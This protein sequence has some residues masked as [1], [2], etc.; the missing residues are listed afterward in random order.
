MGRDIARETFFG[1]RVVHHLSDD[2]VD[3]LMAAPRAIAEHTGGRAFFAEDGDSL[4]KIYAE[5]DALERV[6]VGHVE[7]TS[8][9]ELYPWPL[10]AGLGLLM[11]AAF[12]DE[13]VFRRAP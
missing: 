10:L 8:Y 13:T 5:I 9:R 2:D 1:P 6:D 11:L 3:E 4:A 12:L 7:F